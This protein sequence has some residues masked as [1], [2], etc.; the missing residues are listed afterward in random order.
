MK[1]RI[2]LSIFLFLALANVSLLTAQKDAKA[3]I[4][5]L[6]TAM[7]AALVDQF[8]KYTAT[9]FQVY[10]PFLTEPVPVDVFKGI[11]QGQRA[12]FPDMQHEILDVFVEKDKAS[13]R[14]IFKGTNTGSMQGNPPTGNKVI[15][16]FIVNYDID[17]NGK[18][19]NQYVEFNV[20]SFNAQL[21][22]GLPPMGD[23]IETANKQLASNIMSELS[24]R[25]L[26]GVIKNY[27]ADARFHGWAPQ[28]IDVNGYKAAMTEILNAFPD[29]KFPV[30]DIIAD[31]DK[32]VVRHQLEGTHTGAAFQGIPVTNKKVLVPATVTLRIANGKVVE[33]WLNADFLG[34]MMQLNSDTAM[35]K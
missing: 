26:D 6:F 13:A 4:R 29:S 5:A 14:G 3:N 9:D 30:L 15:L 21:M 17:N 18:I 33:G 1:T 16:P 24:A 32:V 31:G 8:G 19:K 7:D 12:A 25:N 35:K 22:K 23:P 20:A 2:F 10:H 11:I 34:L 28:A 27:A